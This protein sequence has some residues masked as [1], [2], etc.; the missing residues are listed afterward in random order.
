MAT[1]QAAISC[2]QFGVVLALFAWLP[3]PHRAVLRGYR[4]WRR[5]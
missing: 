2:H 4:G 5:L 1:T 3:W